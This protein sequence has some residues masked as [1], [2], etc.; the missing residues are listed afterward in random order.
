MVL[1]MEDCIDVMHALY[2]DYNVL[3]LFNHSC[4]YDRQR[5]D[6]L[7]VENMSKNY[8]GKQ[9][10]LRPTLIREEAGYL[11]TYPHQLSPGDTQHMI[12]G[13]N[14]EGPFWMS[15]QERELNRNDRIEQGK[16]RKRRKSKEELIE[17]LCNKGVHGTG[18]YTNI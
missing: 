18:N 16:T 17:E 5:D 12:F 10:L 15:Q 1:Q 4:G 8:R 14:D 2:P 9:S 11:G 13:E 6:G 7:N 3:F